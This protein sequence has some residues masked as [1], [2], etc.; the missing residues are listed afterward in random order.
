MERVGGGIGASWARKEIVCETGA[1]L[2]T[3]YARGIDTSIPPSFRTFAELK[4]VRNY[5]QIDGGGEV[6]SDVDV[7]V[8]D[9]LSTAVEDEPIKHTQLAEDVEPLSWLEDDD[10]DDFD[11]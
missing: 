11:D 1:V 7:E 2:K 6:D 3:R 10:I 9:L 4:F 5:G 8:G